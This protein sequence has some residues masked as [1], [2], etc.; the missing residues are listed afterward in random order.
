MAQDRVLGE[1][2][3]IIDLT[4]DIA[5]NA[6]AIGN[7]ATGLANDETASADL[8]AGL[9]HAD[10]GTGA[11]TNTHLQIDQHIAA[12]DI[13]FT[14]INGLGDV[15]AP[16]P[17]EGNV[18][19]WQGGSSTWIPGVRVENPMTVSLDTAGFSLFTTDVTTATAADTITI[20]AGNNNYAS[21]NQN[22]GG[23]DIL[24]GVGTNKNYGGAINIKAGASDNYFG[25]VL[26]I[27]GG[28]GNYAGGNGIAGK[29]EILGGY[30]LLPGVKGGAVEIDGGF[31]QA[32]L[33]GAVHITGGGSGSTTG[34]GAGDVN[35]VGGRNNNNTTPQAG[36]DVNI[37]GG[38]T[39]AG[40]E[41]GSVNIKAAGESNNTAGSV[42]IL[43]PGT[44]SA[45]TASISIY[46]TS[47]RYIELKSPEAIL[48]N[49]TWILPQDDPT[50]V[51]GYSLTTD[52]DGVLSFAEP[53]YKPL[54]I[55]S[56]ISTSRELVLGDAGNMVTMNN[57]LAN[58]LVIPTN[59][60]VAFA[61]GT[62]VVISQFGVGQTTFVSGGTGSP[63]TVTIHSTSGLVTLAEQYSAATIIKVATDAWLLTGDLV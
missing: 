1:Q 46:S 25:S 49:R 23:I 10:I 31:S 51:A 26:T 47:I 34:S 55:S 54:I 12:T 15:N 63:P 37:F 50:L 36:G 27:Q 40:G 59:A 53:V 21:G 38:A 35:I 32:G 14:T 18:L 57:A 58:D 7:I 4:G 33:G 11:G 42:N 24:A 28:D 5:T 2:V 43:L 60:T 39:L 19:S 56:D 13:H 61:I 41:S 16:S 45:G 30:G 8:A 22:A 48:G 20:Q 3:D 6:T 9:D 17:A 52:I 29:I 62:E 44:G